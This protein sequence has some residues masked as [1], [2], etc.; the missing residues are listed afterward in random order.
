MKSSKGLIVARSIIFLL[1]SLPFLYLLYAIL[2][3]QDLLGANPAEYLT[4]ETG[5]WSLRFILITLAMTPLRMLSGSSVWI[6]FRR[7]LGLFAFFYVTLHL[8][9]YVFIDLGRDWGHLI[10]DILERPF[11]TIGFLA[12]LLLI[13]LAIT[14][15]RY[16]MRR[17]GKRW[18]KLHQLIYL[19]GTLACIHFIWLVKKDLTEPLIYTIIFFA[20]MLFRYPYSQKATT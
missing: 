8:L 16:M 14:S 3:Q 6:K 17:L 11:I 15:N 7:M 9:V 18:K 4:H 13:P 19:I 20:L 2:K 1:A 10:E 12:W 5:A